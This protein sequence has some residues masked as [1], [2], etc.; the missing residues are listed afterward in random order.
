MLRSIKNINNPTIYLSL[1]PD[2]HEWLYSH[3][4]DNLEGICNGQQVFVHDAS[5]VRV[6]STKREREKKSKRILRS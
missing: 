4:L 1:F 5:V 6:S 2:I 3:E